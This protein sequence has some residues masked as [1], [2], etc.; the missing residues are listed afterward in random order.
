[1]RLS[2]TAGTIAA[3]LP[4]LILSACSKSESTAPPAA[5]RYEHFATVGSSFDHTCAVT[6]GGATYC[7]GANPFS[8]LGETVAGSFCPGRGE[9]NFADGVMPQPYACDSVPHQVSGAPPFVMIGTGIMHSCGFT[10]AH[11]AWCWGGNMFKQLGFSDTTARVTTPTQVM[12][13]TG[14][15]WVSFAVGDLENLVVGEDNDGYVWGSFNFFGAFGP[16]GRLPGLVLSGTP[17]SSFVGSTEGVCAI[18]NGVWSCNDLMGGSWGYP[19]GNDPGFVQIV[20]GSDHLCGLTA[21][22]SAYCWGEGSHGQLGLGSHFP[23][24]QT[25]PAAVIGGH[26]FASLAAGYQMTCG[27]DLSARL[28]CWGNIATSTSVN[29]GVPLARDTTI[30][31]TQITAGFGFMCGISNEQLLYCLGEN[32]NGE[33]AMAQRSFAARRRTSQSC[34]PRDPRGLLRLRPLEDRDVAGLVRDEGRLG[35]CQLGPG[36]GKLRDANKDK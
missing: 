16:G 8:Q 18:Y 30:S 31:F 26:Q 11:D 15:P 35:Y 28:Y 14:V 12:N 2:R 23:T 20:V 7:W 25:V 32:R 3:F 17:V 34:S 22:G 5:L 1:M 10:A 4:S 27:I 36:V 9:A 19:I 33:W 6:I 21:N 24:F 29:P 13:S